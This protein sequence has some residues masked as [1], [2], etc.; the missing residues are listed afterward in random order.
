MTLQCAF[1]VILFSV[2]FL[3]FQQGLANDTY[4]LEKFR[5]YYEN[6]GET[7]KKKRQKRAH[8]S[9]SSPFKNIRIG[10][11]GLNL[12]D[13]GVSGDDRLETH[14][15]FVLD[16]QNIEYLSDFYSHYV[17]TGD[18]QYQRKRIRTVLRLIFRVFTIN[19]TT[20]T[21]PENQE[22]IKAIVTS[23]YEQVFSSVTTRNNES[24]PYYHIFNP[25]PEKHQPEHSDVYNS[26]TLM[27][28]AFLGPYALPNNTFSHY[29]HLLVNGITLSSY[30]QALPNFMMF[31]NTDNYNYP[32]RF[33]NQL[34]AANLNTET[35]L[36]ISLFAMADAA[37]HCMDSDQ[38]WPE[39]LEELLQRFFPC[40]V[41][42]AGYQNIIKLCRKP[43]RSVPEAIYSCSGTLKFIHQI[44]GI[45]LSPPSESGEEGDSSSEDS[46][47]LSWDS[48]Q[49]NEP[50][51][52]NY[53]PQEFS[54]E[55]SSDDEDADDKNSDD[56]NSD[57]E[58]TD[59]EDA[60]DEGTDN[61]G[62]AIEGA[63]NET[64]QEAGAVGGIIS[65][66]LGMYFS[67]KDQ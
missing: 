55:N 20:N 1:R 6:N 59:N 56:K 46:D 24:N 21:S 35:A 33:A 22:Q 50:L 5:Q 28:F 49:D 40:Y 44:L 64:T 42:P 30:R 52:D 13:D 2:L 26:L 19:M 25:A 32:R 29:S 34:I 66:D 16:Q 43:V 3:F 23:L 38:S 4:D 39:T 67:Y 47:D 57:N 17:N 62:A 10:F 7:P 48:S 18:P 60:D 61:E 27:L 31:G 14:E 63:A 41:L 8:D 65:R 58:S 37:Q 45:D 11:F 15:D 53:F 54:S 36:L 51:Q 12:T 9:T